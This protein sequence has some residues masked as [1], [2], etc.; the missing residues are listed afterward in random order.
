MNILLN[1]GENKCECFEYLNA[2]HNLFKAQHDIE[3]INLLSNWNALQNVVPASLMNQLKFVCHKHH[4]QVQNVS[5]L[6]KKC[7]LCSSN[8][9]NKNGFLAGDS[10][11]VCHCWCPFCNITVC[12]ECVISLSLN[13]MLIVENNCDS[14]T[15][16]MQYFIKNKNIVRKVCYTILRPNV[17]V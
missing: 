5:N 6:D 17:C 9:N 14:F 13:Y 3:I 16:I 1:N 7:H 2:L 12:G 15:D 11:I 10:N 8:I 4:E